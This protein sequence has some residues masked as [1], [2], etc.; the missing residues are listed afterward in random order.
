MKKKEEIK[1][2]VRFGRWSVIR[3][4][5]KV[6]LPS[7][8]KSRFFLTKCECGVKKKVGIY[9][10][11]KGTSK[12]CGCLQKELSVKRRTTHGQ[13]GTQFYFIYKSIEDRCQ[14][15][16]HKSYKNYGGRGI[17]CEWNSFEEFY[18][19]MFPTYKKGLSI[20]RI[21]N[22][23][24]YSKTNCR[25]AT[26]AVQSRNRRSNVKFRGEIAKDASIRLGGSDDLVSQRLKIGWDIEKAF[27]T[28]VI[29]S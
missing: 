6:D 27:T 29:K 7:G 23:G 22:N 20:D 4:I 18:K 14:K 13:T 21:D 3:E 9:S 24:N 19:D 8:V 25:W 1:K 17:E 12:S 15:T 16:K 2:G 10:L 28:P 26:T 5:K 11:K